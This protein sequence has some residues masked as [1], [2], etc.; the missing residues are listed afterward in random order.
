MDSLSWL[1]SLRVQTIVYNTSQTAQ[2]YLIEWADIY[3][4]VRIDTVTYLKVLL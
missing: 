2:E 3:N 4:S 1:Q